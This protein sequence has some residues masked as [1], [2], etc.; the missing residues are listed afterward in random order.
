MAALQRLQGSAARRG[1][2][3]HPGL[4]QGVDRGVD[5]RHEEARHARDAPDVLVPGNARLE[6]AQVGLRHRFVRRP[7]EQKRHVDVD[8]FGYQPFHG[9][10]A[11]GRPGHLDHQVGPVDRP[12]QP[13][14]FDQRRAG[15]GGEL[16]GHLEAHEAVR[17]PRPVVHRAQDVRGV[18]YVADRQAFVDGSRVAARTRRGGHGVGVLGTGGERLLE[19][20]RVRGHAAQAVLGDEPRQLAAGNEVPADVVEPDRLAQG[21]KL[22]KRVGA[23]GIHDDRCFKNEPEG[24]PKSRLRSTGQA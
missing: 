7:R 13:P 5:A 21:T 10:H 16:R 22:E 11:G 2:L 12:P 9:R 15:V 6:P 20:R 14:R 8:A 3:R 23:R 17:A 18:A 4:Q 1:L 19:D 24:C